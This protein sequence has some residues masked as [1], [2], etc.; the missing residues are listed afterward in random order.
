MSVPCSPVPCCQLSEA[1]ADDFPT[2][3]QVSPLTPASRC[4]CARCISLAEALIAG[5]QWSDAEA[6]HSRAHCQASPYTRGSGFR[7][8]RRSSLTGALILK[9][10]WG[11]TE[12]RLCAL[13]SRA[14]MPVER[15]QSR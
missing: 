13:L 6:A 2:R 3:C 10:W 12:A 11:K 15:G 7:C 4:C 5:C 1:E 9:Y 8:T 14:L